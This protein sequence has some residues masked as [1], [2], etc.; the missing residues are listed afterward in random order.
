[1]QSILGESD[2]EDK[3][4]IGAEDIQTLLYVFKIWQ[5]SKGTVEAHGK[6]LINK[7]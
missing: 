3:K 5:D 7:R 4:W 1:M 2:G 6:T